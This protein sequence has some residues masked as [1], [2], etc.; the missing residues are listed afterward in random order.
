[1]LMCLI[2]ECCHRPPWEILHNIR[3]MHISSLNYKK[4]NH[5]GSKHF[6]G[7]LTDPYCDES[8]IHHLLG[9]APLWHG[10]PD[11]T[12]QN[13]FLPNSMRPWLCQPCS[14]KWQGEP[15]LLAVPHA[16]HLI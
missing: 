11:L 10:D 13:K 1:M 8:L 7:K 15:N 12:A 5:V 2:K 16:T 4:L 9:A 14:R 6:R 3:Y